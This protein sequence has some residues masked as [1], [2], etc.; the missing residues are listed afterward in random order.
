MHFRGITEKNC[1][2][3]YTYCNPVSRKQNLL[4]ISIATHTLIGWVKLLG[5]FSEAD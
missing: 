3:V 4:Q 2:Y 1:Y 5:V